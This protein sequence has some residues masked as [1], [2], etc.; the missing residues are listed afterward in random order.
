MLTDITTTT[1]GT[2][3]PTAMSSSPPSTPTVASTGEMYIHI[4]GAVSAVAILP[5][6]TSNSRRWCISV[7]DPYGIALISQLCILIGPI[8]DLAVQ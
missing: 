8:R 1:S 3:V 2:T 6:Y 5:F 4:H 7:S